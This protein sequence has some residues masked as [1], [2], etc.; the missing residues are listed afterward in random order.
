[1][2]KLYYKIKDNTCDD[3]EIVSTTVKG[4][5]TYETFSEAKKDLILTLKV[6]AQAEL[7][8]MYGVEELRAKDIKPEIIV[9]KLHYM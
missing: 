6:A 7:E 5:D 8:A 9:P 3:W 1:M 2:E 4:N